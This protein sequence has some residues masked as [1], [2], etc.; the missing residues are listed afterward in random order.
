MTGI[1]LNC[2]VIETAQRLRKTTI[3]TRE[4]IE[5]LDVGHQEDT[6]KIS[7][8]NRGKIGTTAR[9]LSLANS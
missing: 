8:Q 3:K 4:E 6:M 1:L 2:G 9:T 7:A 5:R